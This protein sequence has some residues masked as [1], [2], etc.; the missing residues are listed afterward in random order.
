MRISALEKKETKSKRTSSLKNHHRITCQRHHGDD[1]I[2]YCPQA[3]CAQGRHRP[4]GGMHPT[5][6]PG[7]EACP[8]FKAALVLLNLSDKVLINAAKAVSHPS[9]ATL[10]ETCE[11]GIALLGPWPPNFSILCTA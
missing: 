4:S 7:R 1:F 6:K 8:D 11:I 10:G 2:I 3:G 9:V 5:V